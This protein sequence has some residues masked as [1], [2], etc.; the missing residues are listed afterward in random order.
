M[1]ILKGYIKEKLTRADSDGNH[2]LISRWVNANTVEFDDGK[3][4]E[5]KVTDINNRI[6]SNL[7]DIN[8]QT[9]TYTVASANTVLSSGEKLSVAF[10]KIAKAVSSL[11]SHLADTVSHITSTERTSWN[12]KL[13]STA[14]TTS[15][16]STSTTDALAASA[17]KNLQDQVTELNSDIQNMF[18]GIDTS[19]V[20]TTINTTSASWTATED[21]FVI[22]AA[23]GQNSSTFGIVYIDGVGVGGATSNYANITNIFLPIKKGQVLLTR[24]SGTYNL[25]VY[26]VIR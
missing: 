5:E 23:I 16:A 1:S 12:G 18:F 9:P 8:D 11:I 7:A 26:G 17:G 21:G 20:L 25:T 2:K 24:S 19:N 22:G 4:L 3:T 6:D 14:V 10:G 13:N 15:L